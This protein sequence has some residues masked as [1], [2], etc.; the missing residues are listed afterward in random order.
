MNTETTNAILKS[1]VIPVFY[2]EKIESCLDIIDA[3]YAGGI[4]A[5]EY[6][7]R[8]DAAEKNFPEIVKHVRD[9][10][11]DLKIGIGSVLNHEQAENFIKLGTDFVVSPLLNEKI[12]EQC[13]HHGI[14]WIPGCATPTEIATADELG[15]S[16]I[17]VFPGNVLGPGFIKSVLGPM[18]GLKLMP[19]GGVE[20]SQANLRS[21]FK[22]GACCVGI[23]SQ[24]INRETM[25]NP[26]MI[27]AKI[28][29]IL[30]IIHSFNGINE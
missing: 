19:T 6:L 24:L 28:I 8:G 26:Q 21:W 3:C 7:N 25:E 15:A 16:I 14:C 30:E 10:C 23:G 20:P 4:K 9:H 12:A 11:H 29:E 1:L 22:A 18:P 17:K 27:T 2:E 5:I 13:N